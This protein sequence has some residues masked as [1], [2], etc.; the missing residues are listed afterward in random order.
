M[1]DTTKL[2]TG[3]REVKPRTEFYKDRLRTDGLYGKCKVCK[4]A[5]QRS[6]DAANPKRHAARAL[7][8]QQNNP[9]RAKEIRAGVKRRYLERY[10]ERAAAGVAVRR[11]ISNG[12]LIRP[13]VC[14]ECE[15]PHPRIEGHHDSYDHPLAVRWLCRPCHNDHHRKYPGHP[16]ASP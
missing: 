1:E 13:G 2:C 16:E 12:T 11:A 7:R 6:R 9:K 8:W 4:R 5:S 10:P 3:C 14:S 15:N